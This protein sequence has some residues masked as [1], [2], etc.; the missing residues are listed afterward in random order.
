MNINVFE[1]KYISIFEYTI[2]GLSKI[3]EYLFIHIYGYWFY[4]FYTSTNNYFV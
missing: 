2:F 3:L 4:W 1:F